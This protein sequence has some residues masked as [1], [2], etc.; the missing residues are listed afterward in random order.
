MK[1][2]ARNKLHGTIVDVAKRATTT[3]VRIDV[4]GGAAVKLKKGE[5]AYTVVK[6]T[7]VM[8]GLD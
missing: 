2:S 4:G 7:D 3:Q 6:A 8:V 1:I 5:K